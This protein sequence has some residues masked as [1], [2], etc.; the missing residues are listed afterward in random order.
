MDRQINKIVIHCTDSPD[1]RDLGFHE[2]NEWHKLRFAG[3]EVNGEH[4]YCGYHFII[5]RTGDVEIGRPEPVAGA[6]VAGHN[7]DSIGMVW[8][9]K[10]AIAQEQYSA[11]IH[12][13]ISLMSRYGLEPQNVLGHG[14]LFRGKTCPNLDMNRFRMELE[15]QI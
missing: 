7:W 9:G 5:R 13:C 14:E 6:H 11:L 4:I 12:L 3:V 15:K 8:V 10:K 1:D 2:I